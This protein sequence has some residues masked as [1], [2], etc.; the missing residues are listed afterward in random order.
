MCCAGICADGK[1]SLRYRSGLICG[2][3]ALTLSLVRLKL[4]ELEL[5][6]AYHLQQAI[7]LGFLFCLQLLMEFTKARCSIM[8]RIASRQERRTAHGSWA[9]SS[10]S[11]TSTD[12]G[13]PFLHFAW[14]RKAR[15]VELEIHKNS[16][17]P[18]ASWGLLVPGN[19]TT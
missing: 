4:L 10:D 2:H 1:R 9:S 17:S 11:T 8:V 12:S 14:S 7:D 18:S 13:R 19:R 3:S 15:I 5:L 6:A 16:R